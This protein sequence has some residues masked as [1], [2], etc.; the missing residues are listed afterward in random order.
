MNNRDAWSRT[1]RTVPRGTRNLLLRPRFLV[2][3]HIVVYFPAA[4]DSGAVCFVSDREPGWGKQRQR[5]GAHGQTAAAAGE[6][7]GFGCFCRKTIASLCHGNNGNTKFNDGG[8]CS[9][10]QKYV[11]IM[12]ISWYYHRHCQG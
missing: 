9:R 8:R 4:L 1:R 11:V 10:L 5:A 6:G 7:G 2:A 3:H 12:P